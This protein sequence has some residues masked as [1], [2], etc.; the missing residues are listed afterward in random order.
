[1]KDFSFTDLK[2]AT[3]MAIDIVR[4]GLTVDEQKKVVELL[5]YAIDL[6]G[7]IVSLKEQI[8]AL[9]EENSK[10]KIDANIKEN[11]EHDGK[12]YWL[13]IDSGKND[14]PY[15]PACWGANQLKIHMTVSNHTYKCP[16]CK[17]EV[18]HT[19]YPRPQSVDA[20]RPFG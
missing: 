13:K 2:N 11:L 14:G 16:H 1:M 20:Y 19:D 10:L 12:V 3:G 9:R 8:V 17:N 6:K 4:K 5:E 15:C 7:D 18:I